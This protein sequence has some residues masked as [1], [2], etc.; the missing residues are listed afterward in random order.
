[1]NRGKKILVISH[2]IIN[3]NSVVLPYGREMK[4]F[5]EM[6]EYCLENN[7]GF[8]QLPCPELKQLGLKRWGHLKTQLNFPSY[9]R[10]CSEL[11]KDVVE[12]LEEYISNGY[13][14]LG[15]CGIKGSPT[16][17]VSLTCIGEWQGEISQ[18]SSIEEAKAR[19]KM[20]NEKGIFMEIFH[21]VLEKKKIEIKFFDFDD[22]RENIDKN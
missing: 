4:A 19:V 21:K 1:M 8:I 9:K 20:V 14:I 12:E 5:K 16:C 13:E 2:C 7:I 11:L 3:Q 22:W 6:I 15:V 18:Y 17:G 10:V